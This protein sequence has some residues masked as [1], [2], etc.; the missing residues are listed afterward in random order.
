MDL[1]GIANKSK[2]INQRAW[3]TSYL[4]LTAAKRDERNGN[5]VGDPEGAWVRWIHK[6][7]RP[8]E[9]PPYHSGAAR[10]PLMELLEKG[11]YDVKLD[12]LEMFKLAAWIDL[13]VPFSGDYREG[14]MWSP[15]DHSYYTYYET[16]RARHHDEEKQSVLDWLEN[17]KKENDTAAPGPLDASYRMVLGLTSLVRSENGTMRLTDHA[18]VLTDRLRLRAAADLQITIRGTAKGEVLATSRLGPANGETDLALTAPTRSDRIVIETTPRSAP[19]EVTG[20]HGVTA[21]EIPTAG[22]YHPFL[23]DELR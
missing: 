19:L 2:G 1:R 12:Q 7:S 20:L 5:W 17:T 21:G 13:L 22:G 4:N 3:T 9:L 16:K 18:A 6:Q 23:G 8:T 14:G 11:H 15:R 10:S